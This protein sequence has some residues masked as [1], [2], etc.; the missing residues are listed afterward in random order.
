MRTE[1]IEHFRGATVEDYEDLAR[2][3]MTAFNLLRAVQTC[4]DIAAHIT[5]DERWSPPSSAGGLFLVLSQHG[6]LDSD[7]ARRLSKATG[8]RNFIVH[9]YAGLDI[10]ML[11]RG[12]LEG[13]SDLRAFAA[14]VVTWMTAHGEQD[15]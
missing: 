1:R 12:A 3:D 2:Q 4:I 6:V 11:H 9:E 10:D 5:A 13:P 15:D 7:L 14:Q 8:L